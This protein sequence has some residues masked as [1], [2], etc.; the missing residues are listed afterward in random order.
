M[1]NSG[2]VTGESGMGHVAITTR[3]PYSL[4][5]YFNT[6]FDFPPVG[7]HRREHQRAQV[8]DPLPSRNERHH[9]IA[10]ANFRGLKFD[11]IRTKVQHV[12]IQADSLDH[13]VSSYQQV[14]ELGFRMA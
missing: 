9:S 6:V 8:E 11:P 1:I 3:E 10:I 5:G 4:H 12:N 2:W 7:L 14:P 13:M